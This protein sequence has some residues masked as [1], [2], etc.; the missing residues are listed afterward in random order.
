MK[1][2]FNYTF[3]CIIKNL[4]VYTFSKNLFEHES[5]RTVELEYE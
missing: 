1:M 4:R 3:E 5:C 2:R